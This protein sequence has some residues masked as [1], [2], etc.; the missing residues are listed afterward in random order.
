MESLDDWTQWLKKWLLSDAKPIR[1]KPD[2]IL[3]KDSPGRLSLLN[4]SS[5]D[6][7]LGIELQKKC[8]DWAQIWCEEQ[9][10]G[11][12][13]P[14]LLGNMSVFLR[15]GR[16]LAQFG[17]DEVLRKISDTVFHTSDPSPKFPAI[18]H[19]QFLALHD[20]LQINPQAQLLSRQIFGLDLIGLDFDH[21]QSA[22]ALQS[23]LNRK[24]N[25]ELQSLHRLHGWMILAQQWSCEFNWNPAVKIWYENFSQA[26]LITCSGP[27]RFLSDE[28][29]HRTAW[30]I[31]LSDGFVLRVSA[32]PQELLAGIKSWQNGTETVQFPIFT[33]A[34][35]LSLRPWL[36]TSGLEHL[37][38]AGSD[39]LQ[40][41][42][43][44]ARWL[45]DGWHAGQ[46]LIPQPR[47]PVGDKPKQAQSLNRACYMM[48]VE[49]RSEIPWFWGWIQR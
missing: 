34:S 26:N 23:W 22:G 28:Y 1:H 45:E 24:T 14:P 27:M 40:F 42:S 11:W 19:A 43:P 32:Q 29:D 13:C 9:A 44:D 25:L 12:V 49:S 6:F 7:S 37:L 4:L 35:A 20:P 31:P 30:E 36:E 17:V 2:R 48:I 47:I 8:L 39:D 46:L 18:H 33:Q 41:I 15:N 10:S 38:E 16:L 5:P 3:P 21:L